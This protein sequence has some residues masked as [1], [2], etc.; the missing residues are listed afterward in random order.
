[1][2]N[3]AMTGTKTSWETLL[4]ETSKSF[5]YYWIVMPH[6]K[7]NHCVELS[8]R[9]SNLLTFYFT[10]LFSL[11]EV[12][13]E[14][15]IGERYLKRKEAMERFQLEKQ[16][17]RDE[18]FKSRSKSTTTSSSSHSPSTFLFLMFGNWFQGD[19]PNEPK[20]H[21]LLEIQKRELHCLI[22]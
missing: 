11:G 3:I 13:R 20:S 14:A 9:P 17:K 21:R 18:K 16:M 5:P 4:I 12:E 10:S 15:I 22:S 1:M 8:A 6:N 2:Q 19:P 7:K